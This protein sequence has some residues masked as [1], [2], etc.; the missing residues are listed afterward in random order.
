MLASD[1]LGGSQFS[2]I[3]EVKGVLHGK[4]LSKLLLCLTVL[5]SDV[6]G[7]SQFSYIREVEGVLHGK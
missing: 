3:R 5:A 6:L 7:G 1:V 2:F 4:C